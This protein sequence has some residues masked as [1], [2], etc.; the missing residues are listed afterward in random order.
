MRVDVAPLLLGCLVLA[1]AT[2]SSSA[3]EE[4]PPDSPN[5]YQD[6]FGPPRVETEAE[7]AE[8]ARAQKERMDQ[9]ARFRKNAEA[10]VKRKLVDPD[11]AKFE[12]P[13]LFGWRSWKPFLGKPVS[14]YFTCGLVNARNRMGGYSGAAAFVALMDPKTSLPLLVSVGD[15]GKFDFVD[16]Q[17]KKSVKG[18]PPTRPE[19]LASTSPSPSIVEELA[20]LQ[21]LLAR[22]VLTQ[23]EFEAAK[24]KLLGPSPK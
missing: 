18:L 10:A 21:G 15:G 23:T 12:W 14:G 17:C 13:Y 2:P 24:A 4:P 3:P 22:G 7:R 9:R 6:W 20:T 5:T 16:A 19:A 11:S 1:Q 8:A